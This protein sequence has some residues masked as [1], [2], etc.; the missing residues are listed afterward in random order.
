M[1]DGCIQ[2]KKI[3]NREKKLLQECVVALDEVTETVKYSNIALWI[4]RTI[5]T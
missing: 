5:T 4:F 1:E 2:K 3:G